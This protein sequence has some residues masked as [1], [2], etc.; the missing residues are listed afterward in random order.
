MRERFGVGCASAAPVGEQPKR[1][2]ELATE[3]SEFVLEAWRPLRVGARDDQR[4]PLEV[5]EALAEDVRRDPRQQ[6]L[7][8]VEAARAVEERVDD[9]QRPTLADP[10]E[11][12]G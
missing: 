5:A 7:Q 3:G 6:L 2:G 9:E 8:L 11:R 4:L 12:P 1:A 10:L